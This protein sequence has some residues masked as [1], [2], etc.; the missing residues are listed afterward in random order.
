MRSEEGFAEVALIMVS[1]EDSNSD[2]KSPCPRPRCTRNIS[3]SVISDCCAQTF[4]PQE[5]A[6]CMDRT[7]HGANAPRR[8]EIQAELWENKR[9]ISSPCSK[10]CLNLGLSLEKTFWSALQTSLAQIEEAQRKKGTAQ[11]KC[12]QRTNE[13]KKTPNRSEIADC[14]VVDG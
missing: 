4:L 10:S 2:L 3:V 9:G 14:V 12:S 7:F 5:R 6:T 1:K 13:R 8:E 11:K